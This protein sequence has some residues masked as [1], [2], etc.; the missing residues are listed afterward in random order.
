MEGRLEWR[1]WAADEETCRSSIP[2]LSM[3]LLRHALE[4]PSSL[5]ARAVLLMELELFGGA[6]THDGSPAIL[7]AWFSEWIQVT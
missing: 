6:G 3:V 2:S 1:G 7:T 4:S 5:A